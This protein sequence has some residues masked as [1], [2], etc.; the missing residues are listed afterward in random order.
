[1][2]T[3]F[4]TFIFFVGREFAALR[5]KNIANIKVLFQLMPQPFL[6]INFIAVTSAYLFTNQVASLLQI[7]QDNL[8]SSYA[9]AGYVCQGLGGDLRVFGQ[10]NQYPSVVR[11]ESPVLFYH[12]FLF[13]SI[14]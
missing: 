12:V 5:K 11:K 8:D 14:L 10:V 3:P 6:L 1:L 13:L 2:L 9:K 4:G 7:I